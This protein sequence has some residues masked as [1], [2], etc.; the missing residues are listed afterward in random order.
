MVFDLRINIRGSGS[1]VIKH[2]CTAR[3]STEL[4]TA[5]RLM[6][7]EVEAFRSLEIAPFSL[8]WY[9]GGMISAAGRRLVVFL[10][11]KVTISAIVR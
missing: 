9:F 2:V 1:T 11:S 7:S 6:I 4:G 3:S 10:L 8:S 5:G